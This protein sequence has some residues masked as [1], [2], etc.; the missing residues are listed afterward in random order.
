MKEGNW[1][2]NKM[3]SRFSTWQWQWTQASC[4]FFN[5]IPKY[6]FYELSHKYGLYCQMCKK[7]IY[8]KVFLTIHCYV[9]LLLFLQCHFREQI[10]EI[11]IL[12]KKKKENN[13]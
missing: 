13:L 3:L 12:K 5:T 7:N 2:N 1:D 10:L 6:L 9:F 11:N 8:K 4:K